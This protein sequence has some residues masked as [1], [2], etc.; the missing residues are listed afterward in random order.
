VDTLRALTTPTP[1]LRLHEATRLSRKAL[2]MPLGTAVALRRGDEVLH[3]MP[4][5]S[6]VDGARA[7]QDLLLHAPGRSGVARLV[8]LPP[9]AKLTIDDANGHSGLLTDP[10]SARRWGLRVRH[11]GQAVLLR[12]TPEVEVLPLEGEPARSAL[13]E[14][15]RAAARRLRALFGGP[16]EALPADEALADV[17]AACE[18]LATSPR[19]RP[20]R[21]GGPGALLELPCDR[22]PIVVGDLHGRVDNLLTVLSAP[23]VLGAVESG[24]AYLLFVGDTVHD[25]EHLEDMEGSGLVT[26]ILLRL[27]RRLPDRVFLLLGNHESFGPEC[28]K[29]GVA[30]GLLWGRHLVERRGTAYREALARLYDRLPVIAASAEF[31]ACHAAPPGGRMTANALNDAR[32]DPALMRRLITG[33]ARVPGNPA[34]YTPGDVRRLRR[35]LGL[36][37]DAPFVVGHFPRDREDCVW[38]DVERTVGH[39]VV[40]SA[41]DHQAGLITRVRGEFVAQRHPVEPLARWLRDDA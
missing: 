6:V 20:D 17:H 40:F 24:R 7:S 31:A 41:G 11:D 34:G 16:I 12:G 3:L 10:R 38:L 26:D 21:G 37:Q 15:R 30:Q 8:R 25:E 5:L 22:R 13:V 39:H 1:A 32:R 35:G 4:D 23:D 33:R 29:G 27:M 2:R 9:G 14:Q 18:A 36:D 19:R 28:C